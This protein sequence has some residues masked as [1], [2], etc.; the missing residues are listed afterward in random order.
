[1]RGIRESC[2]SLFLQI[3]RLTKARESFRVVQV[4]IMIPVSCE[5]YQRANL[6]FISSLKVPTAVL[7]KDLFI[8]SEEQSIIYCLL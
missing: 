4:C 1:M 6:D 8:Y 2:G 3:E 5:L 7:V